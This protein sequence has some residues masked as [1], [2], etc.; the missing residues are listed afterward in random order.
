MVC[1]RCVE[2]NAAA[3]SLIDLLREIGKKEC[4]LG[5]ARRPADRPL[6][7]LRLQ[8]GELAVVV[9]GG[10]TVTFPHLPP[11]SGGPASGTVDL[12][13]KRKGEAVPIGKAHIS[14]GLVRVGKLRPAAKCWLFG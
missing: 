14:G 8:G 7:L 1:S 6:A 5:D 10:A 3:I 13:A 9:P 2:D 12:L 4:A 11:V